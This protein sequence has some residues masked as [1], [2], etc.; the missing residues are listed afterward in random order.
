[1]GDRNTF[2]L[3]DEAHR[4]NYSEHHSRMKLVLKGACF[5]AFT[6]T[7]LAKSAKKK[8]PANKKSPGK[9]KKSSK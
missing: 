6:G 5:I 2:V 7:P 3:V 8:S 4:T 9:K 1:M